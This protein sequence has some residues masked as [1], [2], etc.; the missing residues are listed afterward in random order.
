MRLRYYGV[1][2]LGSTCFELD[3]TACSA[4]SPEGKCFSYDMKASGFGRGEGA[5][6]L[7]IKPLRDAIEHGDP[8]HAIVGNTACSQ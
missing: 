1:C 4:L 3:L 7:I 2:L 8:I 5:A 6:A